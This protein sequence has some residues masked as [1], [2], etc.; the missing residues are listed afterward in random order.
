MRQV[1]ITKFLEDGSEEVSY[2]DLPTK[3][4]S[5]RK[6][7]KKKEV[8]DDNNNNQKKEQKQTPRTNKTTIEITRSES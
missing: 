4:K 5:T 1:K 8:V 3:K 2:L 6:P 7:R